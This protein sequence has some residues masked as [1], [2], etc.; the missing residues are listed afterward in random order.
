MSDAR[1]DHAPRAPERLAPGDTQRIAEG[2]RPTRQITRKRA[3]TEPIVA[4]L[5][6]GMKAE[7]WTTVLSGKGLS[8]R[9]RMIST[10]M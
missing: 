4:N 1:M 7:D 8:R 6:Q 2:K 3:L 9:C 10:F 5:P